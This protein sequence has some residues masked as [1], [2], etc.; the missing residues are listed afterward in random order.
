MSKAASVKAFEARFEIIK[1]TLE[2]GEDALITGFGKFCVKQKGKHSGRNP[3]TGER[4]MLP[5]RQSVTF[6][7][8]SVL[9]R[10]VNRGQ[11]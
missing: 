11:E 1:K 3:E 5:E 7:C 4:L 6:K 9:K 10:N 8:S 2:G